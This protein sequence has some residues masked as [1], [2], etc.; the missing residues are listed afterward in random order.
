MYTV[1]VG[2]I[3]HIGCMCNIFMA[4]GCHLLGPSRCK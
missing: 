4:F 3:C 2:E 1:F